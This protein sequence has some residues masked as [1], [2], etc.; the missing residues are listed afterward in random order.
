MKA[1]RQAE[2]GQAELGQVDRILILGWGLIGDLFIR[3]PLI[4]ALKEHFPNAEITVVVDPVCTVVLENHPACDHIIAFS[5][6]KRPLKKYLKRYLS[7]VIKLRRQRFDLCVNLYCGGG[8]ALISQLINARTR[9]CFDHTPA[10]C[11][12]NNLMVPRPSFCE[13]WTLDFSR[14]LIPLG[15]PLDSIRRGTS[16]YCSQEAK[17]FAENFLSENHAGLIAFN[18]G[19]GADEKRWPVDRFVELAIKINQEYG[20]KPLV[21]TNPGMEQLA[22]EF[23]SSYNRHGKAIQA[24]LVSIDQVAGMM[25]HCDYVVTGDTALMHLAFGMKRPTLALFTYSRPETVEPEDVPHVCCFVAGKGDKDACG[26][27]MGTA[28]IPLDEAY[29]QFC[30]LVK[31]TS[32]NTPVVS[33]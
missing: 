23:I 15:I 29:H 12:S 7:Q 28:N 13:N 8:S 10:L 31:F 32:N 17:A 24:P 33:D 18:L 6:E 4:E 22:G 27:L 21:F 1:V 30:N 26:N 5:R 9:V 16:F 19:A 20:L 11:R 2:L 14:M 25:L 3:V